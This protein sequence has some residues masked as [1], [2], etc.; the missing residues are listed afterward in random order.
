MLSPDPGRQQ[1]R[2]P[3]FQFISGRQDFPSGPIHVYVMFLD[4]N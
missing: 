1:L 3:I 4:L 2:S